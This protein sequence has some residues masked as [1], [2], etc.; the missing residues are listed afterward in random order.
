[1]N[2]TIRIIWL[3]LR[4]ILIDATITLIDDELN[5]PAALRDMYHMSDRLPE[6][7]LYPQPD[8]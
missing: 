1:M 2:W 8:P 4:L 5:E 3:C 7:V 6:N